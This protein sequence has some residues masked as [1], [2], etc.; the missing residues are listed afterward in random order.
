MRVFS[1][2]LND[3]RPI[4]FGF[5][6]DDGQFKFISKGD[7]GEVGEMVATAIARFRLAL[8]KDFFDFQVF[9]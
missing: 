6:G 1:A 4:L 7:I 3:D 5:I 8:E 9:E 2:N